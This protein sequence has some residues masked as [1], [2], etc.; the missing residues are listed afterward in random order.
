M[1]LATTDLSKAIANGPY[2]IVLTDPPWYYYGDPNKMAAA[3]KHYSLMTNEDIMALPVE[4]MITKTGILFMWCTSST[5]EIAI[6]CIKAWGMHYRGVGFVWV[7][8]KQDG[9]PMGARGVRP[10]II[11]PLTEF[12]LLGSKVPKGRPMKLHDESIRQTIFAPVGAHSAKPLS[13]HYSIESMYPNTNKLEMFARK[14][15]P[16]WTCWGNQVLENENDT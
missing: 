9:T 3:G 8:T 6:E 2:D 13:V 12:V 1:T 5:L 4:K 11:K 14:P 10:S 15:Q 7:K 16:G